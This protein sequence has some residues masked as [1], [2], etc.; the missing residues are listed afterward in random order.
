MKINK[1]IKTITC[2]CKEYRIAK[3]IW[4]MKY[5]V[6]GL[7][8]PDFKTYY[9]SSKRI[10][11]LDQWNKIKSPEA[12]VYVCDQLVSTKVPSNSLEK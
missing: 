8:L 4:K 9:K 10:G 1:L 5:K 12:D 2:K 7:I 3:T 11:T 6:E